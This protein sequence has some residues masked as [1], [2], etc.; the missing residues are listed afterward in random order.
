MITWLIGMAVR[1]LFD[2]VLILVR[3]LFGTAWTTA[4]SKIASVLQLPGISTGLG[5][6][7]TFVGIDFT[8]WALGLAVTI[9]IT[10]RVIRLVIG[11]LSKG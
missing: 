8:V 1:A 5:I 9:I 3:T 4:T 6:Y 2:G 7:D 10:I 11:V